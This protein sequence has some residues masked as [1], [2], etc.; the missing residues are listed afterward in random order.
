LSVIKNKY[1]HGDLKAA[2]VEAAFRILAEQGADALSLRSAARLA[3]VSHA[4][5]YAHFEDKEDLISALKDFGFNEL[6]QQLVTGVAGVGK[7]PFERLRTFGRVYL[8]FAFTQSAKYQIMMR[9][10]LQKEPRATA[11]YVETGRRIFALL[12]EEVRAL[13][14]VRPPSGP[15]SAELFVMTAWSSLHGLCSLWMDGPMAM[16]VPPGTK[17]EALAEEFIEYLLSTAGVK[18]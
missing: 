5:P 1:H 6:L 15:F 4:A 7:D 13:H 9:R 3:G 14:A 2:L 17:V 11:T 12:S 10:P 8:N 18:A 16:I